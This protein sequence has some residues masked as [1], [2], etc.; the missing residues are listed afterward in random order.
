V[1]AESVGRAGYLGGYDPNDLAFVLVAL[2]P[3]VVAFALICTGWKRWLCMGIA[4]CSLFVTLLTVSRGG[5]LGLATDLA[6]ISLFLTPKGAHSP[7][8]RRVWT[9]TTRVFVLGAVF[10]VAWL[11]VPESARE[12]LSTIMS[13][14]SDYNVTSDQ[15]RLVIWERNLPLVAKRPWG[16]GAGASP[17]VD[18]RLAGGRYRALHNMYLEVLVELGIVGFVLFLMTFIR[19]WRALLPSSRHNAGS[20]ELASENEEVA[21][22]ARALAIGFAGVAVSGFFLS[23]SYSNVLWLLVALACAVSQHIAPGISPRRPPGGK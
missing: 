12:Q 16:Y 18:G 3:I 15:G 9:R 22:F 17:A 19:A 23:V 10:T 7:K 11:S 5:L 8:K 6:L 1:K 20:N 2:L 4:C 13:V 21:Q 14:S